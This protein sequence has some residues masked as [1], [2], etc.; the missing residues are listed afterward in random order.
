MRFKQAAIYD[1]LSRLLS[2]EISDKTENIIEQR[3]SLINKLEALATGNTQD[4]SYI[5][6][7]LFEEIS[8]E[9][10]LDQSQSTKRN[11]S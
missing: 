6:S 7:P 10:M 1:T 3:A 4:N 11:I 5:A 2:M 8:K 9:L